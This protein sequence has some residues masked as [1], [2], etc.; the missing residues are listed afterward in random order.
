MLQHRYFHVHPSWVP[1]VPI[2]AWFITLWVLLGVWLAQGR[3][4]YPSM[5]ESIAYIS[6]CGATYLKPLFVVGCIITGIG[7]FAT[8][9]VDGLLRRAGILER[10]GRRKV[11]WL[12]YLSIASAFVG[13][14]GLILLSGFDTLRYPHEHHAFLAVFMVGVILSAIFTIAEYA[15]LMRSPNVHNTRWLTLSFYGKILVFVL[16]LALA[17]AFGVCLNNGHLYNP[18]AI[19]E[20]I[21]AFVFEFYLVTFWADLHPANAVLHERDGDVEAR[22]VD[23]SMAGTAPRAPKGARSGATSS[24]QPQMSNAPKGTAGMVLNV[25]RAPAAAVRT[26]GAPRA[27]MFTRPARKG[28]AVPVQA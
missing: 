18:G 8:L 22:M 6:D 24:A 14:L 16:E 19:I 12:S 10:T 2:V 13:C 23:P 21:V 11:R 28:A 15:A 17:I 26:N 27:P 7:F 5:E 25:P 1:V 9:L 4:Q 3:P 20:W